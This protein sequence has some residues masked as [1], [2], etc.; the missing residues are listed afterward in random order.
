MNNMRSFFS[1]LCHSPIPRHTVVMLIALAWSSLAFCGEIHDAARYGNLER[2]KALVKGNPDLVFSKDE[3]GATPLLIAALGGHKDIAELL[4]ANKA[5]VNATNNYR[6]TP[7]HVSALKGYKDIAALLL[8]NNA[9]VNA[10]DSDGDTALKLAASGG[11][12][13]LVELLR[14][15]GGKDATPTDARSKDASSATIFDAVKSGDMKEV[16]ALLKVNP[17][18]VFSKD[19]NGVTAL[20]WAT[21]NGHKDVAELL[22]SHEADVNG[23]DGV[24]GWTALHYAANHGNKDIAELLLS[25]GADVNAKGKKGETPLDR[26]AGNGNK[27]MVEWLRQ[28]GGHAEVKLPAKGGIVDYVELLR[29]HGV[30]DATPTDATSK[31]ASAATIFVAASAG[32]LEKVKALLKDHPDLVFSKDESALGWGKTP[33]HCAASAG[34]RDVVELLL[35]NKADVNAK[36]KV[37]ATPLHEAV[38]ANLYPLALERRK[39]VTELV[40]ANKNV[41]ELLLGNK[42]KVNARDNDGLT[43]LHYAVVFPGHKDM[44]ELLLANKADVNAKAKNGWTPLHLAR[45]FSG[46]DL[47]KDVEELLRQ[48]GGHE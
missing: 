46:K 21:V 37:G 24:D 19:P 17:D 26:A 4:L 7:L 42:A 6:M 20:D 48:H 14:Q 41:A 39:N 8:A 32:D 27:E 35:A 33:L 23:K 15:H 44:V 18:L 3:N 13:E 29:Q 5:E 45:V 10:K 25:H 16:K 47:D 36:D 22:L 30:K 40:V 38:G 1:G 2:V 43:P 9:E 11:F 12:T 28:H 34:Y 31:D